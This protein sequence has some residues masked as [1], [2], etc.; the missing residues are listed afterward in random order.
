MPFQP[1]ESLVYHIKDDYFEKADDEELMINKGKGKSRPALFYMVD[2]KNPDIFWM[3]PLSTKVEKYT[4]LRDKIMKIHGKCNGIVIDSYDGIDSAFLP[5][6]MFPVIAS[7]LSHTHKDEKTNRPLPIDKKLF[8]KIKNKAQ[9]LRFNYIGGKRDELIYTDIYRLKALMLE[10]QKSIRLSQNYHELAV[11]HPSR[12]LIYPH[13]DKFIALSKA[14]EQL[15]E[16]LSLPTEQISIGA[17]VTDVANIISVNSANISKTIEE[18][19]KNGIDLAVSNA[20][21]SYSA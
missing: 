7:Y 20:D 14:A 8:M 18:L 2:R 17:K 3:I 10:E 4:G 1:K 11:K 16:I 19:R 6:G 21:G 9:T 15:A 5:Q 13:D 12:L